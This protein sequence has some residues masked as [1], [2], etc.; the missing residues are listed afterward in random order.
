MA[1]DKADPSQSQN[2]AAELYQLHAVAG[3]HPG[4]QNRKRNRK[5]H[6]R[7]GGTAAVR[8]RGSLFMIF[9]IGLGD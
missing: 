5:Q 2:D 4:L 6:D 7:A 9:M 8:S 3:R 1:L